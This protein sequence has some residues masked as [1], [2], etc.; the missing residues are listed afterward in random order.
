MSDNPRAAFR[1]HTLGLMIAIHKLEL[2]DA[3]FME[4]LADIKVK[5]VHERVMIKVFNRV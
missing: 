1:N 5:Q 4:Q 2:V 3:E